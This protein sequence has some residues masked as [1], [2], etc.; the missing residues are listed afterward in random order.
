MSVLQAALSLGMAIMAGSPQAGECEANF[1]SEGSF[2]SGR[3]YTTSQTFPAP[4]EAVYRRAYAAMV[5]E[6][7]AIRSSDREM[8]VISATTEVSFGSGKTAPLNIIVEPTGDGSRVS[9]T[10]SISGGL[11][12]SDP[13][14]NMCS[15]M[16]K[17]TPAG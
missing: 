16:A 3:R 12:A 9:M 10:F 13:R 7:W 5:Q 11:S 8:M 14:G 1:R 2:F 4:A 15:L 17:F 6:G